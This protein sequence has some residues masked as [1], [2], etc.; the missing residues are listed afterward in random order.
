MQ[1]WGRRPHCN[2]AR[3]RWFYRPIIFAHREVTIGSVLDAKLQTDTEQFVPGF[4]SKPMPYYFN[5]MPDGF[6]VE[7]FIDSWDA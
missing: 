1:D 5:E 6:D 7:D 2:G 4:Q 3:S